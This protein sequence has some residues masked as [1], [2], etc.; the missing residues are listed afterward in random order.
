MNRPGVLVRFA[1]Y[2]PMATVLFLGY[3][4]VVLGWY[5]G[6]LAW[7]L[8]LGAVGA[9]GR[10]LRAV[11]EVRSYKGWLAEW[12][13]MGGD[14]APPRPRKNRLRGWLVVIGAAFIAVAIPLSMPP[15]ARPSGALALIWCVACL[16]LVWKLFS[17]F[18]RAIMRSSSRSATRKQAKAEDA[19][20]AWL[21][22]PASSSPSR[23]EAEAN[24]PEYCARLI[25]RSSG[26]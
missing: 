15:G 18:R 11:R 21:L 1:G 5:Q 12:E 13:A 10:T 20:V 4:A 22:P 14:N 24:L 3:V 26:G 7:W 2:P 25:S 16:I 23:A 9:A 17:A 19:P 6:H 8:A